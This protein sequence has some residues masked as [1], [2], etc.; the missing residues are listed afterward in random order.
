MRTTD[1][2]ARLPPV[3]ARQTRLLVTVRAQI[4][5]AGGTTSSLALRRAQAL[6]HA[7]AGDR[8]ALAD[9]LQALEDDDPWLAYV[10]AVAARVDEPLSPGWPRRILAEPGPW[11]R[12][13]FEAARQKLLFTPSHS[14]AAPMTALLAENPAHEGA[15]RWVEWSARP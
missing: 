13:R 14:D 11:L 3:R 1:L 2:A 12:L 4:A 10:E 15:R 6:L 5:R 9:A 7:L 8:D